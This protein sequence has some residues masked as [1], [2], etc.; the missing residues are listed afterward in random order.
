MK[1]KAKKDE[2]NNRPDIDV[3]ISYFEYVNKESEFDIYEE[4]IR[5]TYGNVDVSLPLDDYTIQSQSN[6][7]EETLTQP[8]QHQTPIKQSNHEVTS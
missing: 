6:S 8:N 5:E 3:F 7:H 2:F 4:Y 1:F